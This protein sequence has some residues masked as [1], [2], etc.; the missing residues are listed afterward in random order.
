MN[1]L[2]VVATP[3][4]L[5]LC[6]AFVVQVGVFGQGQQTPNPPQTPN[7]AFA[8]VT[9]DSALPRV[10]LIGDSISIGYTLPTRRVLQGKA[11]LHRIPVN[12][13]PTINGLE[14]LDKWLG[15]GKWNVIHFNWG[16]HDLR[17]M[18]D[19]K[20]QVALDR[21]EENLRNLVGRLKRT[22]AALIWASTTPV[23]D[24]AVTPPRKNS[25]VIAYNAVAQRIMEEN[26]IPIDD[27]YAVAFPRL[28]EV[29]Q[30]A[31]VHYTDAGYEVLAER[32]AASIRAAL[33]S[34]R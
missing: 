34:S 1:R 23:P 2:G 9:D 16:L 19:G 7:P 3:A 8:E 5:A 18:E 30:P 6:G 20:H 13:G 24:A 31:N 28:G 17:F 14:N 33:A 4:L 22:G 21:Y 26:G 11:N 10:L 29:Q 27:L 12:G 25:D 32:V 15:S